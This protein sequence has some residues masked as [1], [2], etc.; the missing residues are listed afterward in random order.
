M[1]ASLDPAQ[2]LAKTNT[3]FLVGDI[4]KVLIGCNTLASVHIGPG[5]SDN[6]EAKAVMGY[7]SHSVKELLLNLKNVP[8][9]FAN[10]SVT[11]Q[12]VEPENYFTSSPSTQYPTIHTDFRPFIHERN[13]PEKIIT[14]ATKIFFSRYENQFAVGEPLFAGLFKCT[15]VR[16]D[17]KSGDKIHNQTYHKQL[18]GNT[19]NELLKLNDSDSVT[20]LSI[21][22]LENFGWMFGVHDSSSES[23]HHLTFLLA[24]LLAVLMVTLVVTLV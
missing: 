2:Y 1:T 15:L 21:A 16:Y 20:N 12:C 23:F 24:Q 22:C 14:N 7:F 13:E 18:A 3:A 9:S 17:W 5:A 10:G 8:R 6:G 4:S 11:H 19:T